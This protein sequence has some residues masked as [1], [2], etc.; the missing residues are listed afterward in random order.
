MNLVGA[1][2]S[3]SDDDDD[4]DRDKASVLS[5]SQEQPGPLPKVAGTNNERKIVRSKGEMTSSTA[6]SINSGPMKKRKRERKK[7]S[8][9]T[10]TPTAAKSRRKKT[11]AVVNALVLSPEIQAALARGDTL[12]D[13]DSDESPANKPP[14]VLRPAGSN[15]NDLLS[16]LP[17][18][19][20][21]ASADDIF[22]KSQLKR[23]K[24]ATAKSAQESAQQSGSR[25]DKGSEAASQP[26][27]SSEEGAAPPPAPPAGRTTARIMPTGQT[28]QG[29]ASEE[30]SDSDDG[31]DLLANMHAKSSSTAT[32][33]PLFT[34]PSR[35]KVLPIATTAAT[36]PPLK[37]SDGAVVPLGGGAAGT[38]QAHVPAYFDED[39]TASKQSMGQ[40][41]RQ[42]VHPQGG[43]PVDQRWTGALH[44]GAGGTPGAVVAST[45]ERPQQQSVGK[46]YES[47]YQVGYS[48]S[49]VWPRADFEYRGS[50]AT[51]KLKHH[52]RGR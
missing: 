17:Q 18:P 1:Y 52:S 45:W 11:K 31:D 26:T 41:E 36:S 12:G 46:G 39:E 48:V 24:A 19:S 47:S 5:P 33:P 50:S 38:D 16:L 22:L 27:K 3:S 42:G 10:Q 29:N 44:T 23:R 51:A 20:T 4:D 2:D 35:A 9:T 7:S 30:E 37:T 25:A 15:P 43:P 8:N 49:C 28:E 21:S 14:K 40:W 32:T 13:S 34:L 6:T